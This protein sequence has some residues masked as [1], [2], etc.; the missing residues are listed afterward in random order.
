MREVFVWFSAILS[1]NAVLCHT[2]SESGDN[3]FQSLFKATKVV[4][5]W[6]IRQAQ[7]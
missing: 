3:F 7:L 1:W 5:K 6:Q 4:N 2:L